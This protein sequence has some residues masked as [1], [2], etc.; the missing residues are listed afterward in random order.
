MVRRIK[1]AHIGNT[2]NVAYYYSFLLKQYNVES[3][4]FQTNSP[5]SQM[6]K[7]YYGYESGNP[8]N[9][10]LEFYDEKK[11]IFK[12]REIANTYDILELHEGGGFFSPALRITTAKK[13]AHFHG[14]ELRSQKLNKI[15]LRMVLRLAGFNHIFLSTDDLVNYIW[16]K[17]A[18]VLL[19]PIDPYLSSI[20]TNSG[21]YI[22]L[23]TRLD[24]K[25]KGSNYF[26]SAWKTIRE[27][28]PEI[29]LIAINWGPDSKKYMNMT[30][31]DKKITWLPLQNRNDYVDILSKADLVV[32]Q[33]NFNILSL[34]EE[35]SISLKKPVV[36]LKASNTNEPKKIANEIVQLFTDKN[37]LETT[38][39]NQSSMISP[40]NSS[41]LS[42]QLYNAYIK[43]LGIA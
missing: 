28:L 4:I 6:V 41:S 15:L 35:E 36:S 42:K 14:T 29:K 24:D 16:D 13:I 38:I 27:K 1:V 20:K 31:N 7:T 8:L 43:L 18:E 12:F 10:N 39:N 22:F 11:K 30:N 19:N 21:G 32:G 34:I 26:F 37:Y 3:T 25:I 9:L 17:K 33:F 5:S 2:A 23:P 40:F